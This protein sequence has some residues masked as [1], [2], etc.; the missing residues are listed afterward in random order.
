MSP[1]IVIKH[2]GGVRETSIALGITTACV[3]KWRKNGKIPY[4]SQVLVE[5]RS[6]GKFKAKKATK[7]C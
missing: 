6:D 1:E 3:Y 7:K 5:L 4:C 2:Y